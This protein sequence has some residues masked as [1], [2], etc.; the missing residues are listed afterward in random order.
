MAATVDCFELPDNLTAFVES[1]SSLE[2]MGLLIQNAGWSIR[3][4]G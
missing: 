1:R 2:C 3:I 4:P